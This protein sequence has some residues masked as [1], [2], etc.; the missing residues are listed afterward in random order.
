MK[1]LLLL[2]AT[3]ILLNSCKKQE[4]NNYYTTNINSDTTKKHNQILHITNSPSIDLLNNWFYIEYNIPLG[5]ELDYIRLNAT[6][7]SQPQ[8]NWDYLI[9]YIN[10]SSVYGNPLINGS[11][12]TYPVSAF[13]YSQ[14]NT[15]L[16]S[17]FINLKNLN[18]KSPTTI[19]ISLP[20][21][22]TWIN[23]DI[24]ITQY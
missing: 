1:S 8:N 2:T 24:A 22:A 20:G 6:R 15:S 17:K 12:Y 23:C 5:Y 16:Y 10:Q 21:D 4:V 18:I 3:I 9:Q 13:D 14:F 7:Y 11:I 19:H